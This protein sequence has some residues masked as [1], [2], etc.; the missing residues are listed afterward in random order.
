LKTKECFVLPLVSM[1]T[2]LVV[3]TGVLPVPSPVHPPP[4]RRSIYQV[5]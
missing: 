1:M 2:P 3:P 5:L 4:P